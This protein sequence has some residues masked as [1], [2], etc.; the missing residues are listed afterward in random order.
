MSSRK[1]TKKTSYR[2]N[3]DS[4]YETMESEIDLLPPF[5]AINTRDND[6]IDDRFALKCQNYKQIQNY[7]L[8]AEIREDE[9][10]TLCIRNDNIFRGPMVMKGQPAGEILMKI[11]AYNPRLWDGEDM[12]LQVLNSQESVDVIIFVEKNTQKSELVNILNYLEIPELEK[13]LIKE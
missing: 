11:Y 12:D 8:I 9:R 1:L 7:T 5:L 3:P 4:D 2:W 6:G 10:R 13:K